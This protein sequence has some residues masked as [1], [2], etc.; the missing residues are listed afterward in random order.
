MMGNQLEK[1]S[2]IYIYIYIY[3]KFVSHNLFDILLYLYLFYTDGRA[4]YQPHVNGSSNKAFIRE[5]IFNPT[6]HTVRFVDAI[7]TF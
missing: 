5:K 3:I 4:K 1:V 2:F 7:F 6:L